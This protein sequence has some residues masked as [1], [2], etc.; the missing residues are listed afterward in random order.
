MA[1]QSALALAIENEIAA[2]SD[3]ENSVEKALAHLRAVGVGYL[4]FA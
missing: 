4:R 2:I 3:I 1:A